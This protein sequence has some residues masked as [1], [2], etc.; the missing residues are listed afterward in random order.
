MKFETVMQLTG[1]W[2]GTLKYFPSDPE[3]R[4]GIAQQIAKMVR[5]EDQL[6]WLVDVVPTLYSDWPALREIRALFCMKFPPL[7]GIEAVSETFPDGLTRE[8]L[9]PGKKLALPAPEPLRLTGSTETTADPEMI[10]LVAECAKPTRLSVR[11]PP[12]MTELLPG[13][14][15]IQGLIRHSRKYAPAEPEP[16]TASQ[17]EI[18][19]IREQQE[20]NRIAQMERKTA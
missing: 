18:D 6:R 10:A 17:A 4:L 8:Q 1:Q 5:S 9:N 20:R 7:D 2:G 15:E 11:V 16:R 3:A 19:L 12:E 14:S 13:E